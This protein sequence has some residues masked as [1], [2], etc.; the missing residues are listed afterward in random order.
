MHNHWQGH[1]RPWFNNNWWNNHGN[2]HLWWGNHYYNRP[3]GYWWGVPTWG[4]VT[5]F[6][7]GGA[8]GQPTYYDY[9]SNVTY[10]ND[11]VYVN[12]A[13]V[14]T[15]EEYAATAQALAAT[16]IP[17]TKEEQEKTEWMPLGVFALSLSA[18]EK[19][20]PRLMQLAISKEGLISG[21]YFN[22]EADKAVPIQ[23]AVDRTTQRA[24]WTVGDNKTTVF[25]TGVFNLT[26]N[27]TPV[28]VHHGDNK[29]DSYLMV[30]MDK[31]AETDEALR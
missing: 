27:E 14:A 19:E 28:L 30:R 13:P 3:W 4:A 8:W 6:V 16:P 15:G 25:D 24:C 5:A 21:V 1:T 7:V 12:E 23:G 29:T 22:T 20:S 2:C 17:A 18:D 11:T 10:V 26:Q 31:P 9:G